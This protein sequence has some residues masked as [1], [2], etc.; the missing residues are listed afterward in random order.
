MP[1]DSVFLDTN[2]LLYFFDERHQAKRTAARDWVARLWEHKAARLSWQVL[3]E[4]YA[5]AH[6][7]IGLPIS[8][9]RSAILL[10]AQLEAVDT[11]A[12][13]MQRGW[14]WMDSARLNWWDALILASAEQLD[15]RWLLSEDFQAGRKYGDV[16][17][18]NPFTKTPEE[19]GFGGIGVLERSN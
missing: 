8:E 13:L 17:V 7:K 6:P 19:L 2:V 12:H 11:S 18:V 15:C 5:N 9:A 10:F 14:H 3:N 1:G 16:T 4:F